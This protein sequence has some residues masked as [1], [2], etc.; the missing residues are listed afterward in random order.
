MGLERGSLN[1]QSVEIE[2]LGRFIPA[3]VGGLNGGIR[4]TIVLLVDGICSN[5]DIR[6][7]NRTFVRLRKME[8]NAEAG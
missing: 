5:I 1:S 7:M 4:E 8:I 2:A 6:F 3:R